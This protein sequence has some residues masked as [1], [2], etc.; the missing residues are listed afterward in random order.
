MTKDQK[1]YVLIFGAVCCFFLD[2]IARGHDYISFEEKQCIDQGGTVTYGLPTAYGGSTDFKQYADG[3]DFSRITHSH[4][5]FEDMEKEK[6]H[7]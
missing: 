7:I 6:K 5:S 2:F 4:E 3:C 1:I